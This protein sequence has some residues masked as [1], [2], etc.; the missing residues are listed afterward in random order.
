MTAMKRVSP[1]GAAI[2]STTET[3][4]ASLFAFLF[5]GELLY[6]IQMVGATFIL[7]AIVLLMVPSKY[8]PEPT[9]IAH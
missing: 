8:K 6:P 3:V 9:E 5:L 1:T 2:A 7:C 4:M